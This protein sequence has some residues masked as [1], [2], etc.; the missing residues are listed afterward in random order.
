MSGNP[1]FE[2]TYETLR[3]MKNVC[4]EGIFGDARVIFEHD[5]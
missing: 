3:Y 1:T 4:S 5:I 2:E